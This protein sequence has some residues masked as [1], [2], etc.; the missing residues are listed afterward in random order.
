M[1]RS[2]Q[3]AP[4]LAVPAVRK[5]R[6]IMNAR[7]R[8]AH[9]DA[10]I[11][12]RP[13][14]AARWASTDIAPPQPEN[15]SAAGTRIRKMPWSILPKLKESPVPVIM[16]AASR[17]DAALVLNPMIRK[18]TSTAMTISS[19]SS[20]ARGGIESKSMIGPGGGSNWASGWS[21]MPLYPRSPSSART[22]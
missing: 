16:A 6:P 14:R 17:R 15:A 22:P 8:M 19:A 9:W 12:G 7:R 1:W 13:D 20:A 2:S 11:R 21:A 5:A 18:T 10:S 4:T 3:P